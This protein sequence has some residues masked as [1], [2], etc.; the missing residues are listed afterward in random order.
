[1]AYRKYMNG[2]YATRCSSIEILKEEID[3]LFSKHKEYYFR[4]QPDH[5]Y[6]LISSFD[7]MV[8]TFETDLA[9]DELLE[10]HLNYFRR[11]VRGRINESSVFSDDNFAWSIGQHYGLKTPLLDWSRSPYISL[12]FAVIELDDKDASL[13][14][15]D[16][17]Y[18]E[19]LNKRVGKNTKLLSMNKETKRLP[20][21]GFIDPM[22]HINNRLI[23]QNGLFTRAPISID[24]ETWI[25]TF[26][27]FKNEK[28]L[29]K[30]EIDSEIKED[31]IE[32][33]EQANINYSTVY[34]DL[35]GVAL[36]SNRIMKYI[37]EDKRIEKEYFD[38]FSEFNKN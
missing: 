21:I 28:I 34:P 35:E 11:F 6:K 30:I 27:E 38:I 20:T 26:E 8:K 1:M 23:Q 29:I 32:W 4:G 7:R 12:F 9:R 14:R 17:N 31:I 33:L 36:H 18:I 15:I 2:C 25:D 5:S 22:S 24:I 3:L 37:D 16:K 19:E 13:Y 10:R